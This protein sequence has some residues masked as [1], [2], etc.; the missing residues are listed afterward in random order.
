MI[1][2]GII[3]TGRIAKRMIP[4]VESVPGIDIKA[5]YNPH[6]GSAAGFVEKNG[7]N[8]VQPFTDLES[9]FEIIDAVYIASPHETHVTYAKMAIN[10]G[11]HVLCEKP[12]SLSK[13]E[14]KEIYDLSDEKNVV[15]L[16]GIKTAFCPGFEK[17]IELIKEGN[18]GTIHNVEACF[19]RLTDPTGRELSD[20]EYG[21]SLTELGSYV[22]F[23]IFRILGSGDE[24]IRIES[25][26]SANGVDIYTKV[27]FTYNNAFATATAGLGVKSD[28]RLM[29]SGTEGYILV[30]PPWWKTAHIEVHFE[31]TS[32]KQAYEIPYEGDG[33]RYE[34]VELISRIEGKKSRRGVTEAESMAIAGVMEML[35]KSRGNI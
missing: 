22:L 14:V 26:K 19:T 1:R 5:V 10:A 20:R 4:E 21:G 35:L 31:D 6:K 24:S 8:E 23:P 28:G 2:L 33:L 17:V 27:S 13:N 15:F 12:M 3:G 29:I 18:I 7:L 34:L 9:F 25:I 32:Q 30:T 16:E 11:K